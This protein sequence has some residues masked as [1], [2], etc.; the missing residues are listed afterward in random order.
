MHRPYPKQAIEQLINKVVK[1][2][3]EKLYTYLSKIRNALLHGDDTD[4]IEKSIPIELSKLVDILGKVVWVSLIS[5]F[6]PPSDSQGLAF[7]QANRYCHNKIVTT[8][9]MKLGSGVSKDDPQIES[10]ANVN[11]TMHVHDNQDIQG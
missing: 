3:P 1:D 9:I 4:E 10:V 8:A 2:D 11:I 7:L 6:K 5:S